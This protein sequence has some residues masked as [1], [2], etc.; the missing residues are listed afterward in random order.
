[1]NEPFTATTARR[2]RT[3]ASTS[4]LTSQFWLNLGSIML[5]IKELRAETSAYQMLILHNI[6]TFSVHWT[7]TTLWHSQGLQDAA[8][9]AN[10][11]LL[12]RNCSAVTCQRP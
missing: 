3:K 6:V 4:Q 7:E 12:S 5:L 10:E 8:F 9:G 2:I 1:M 11:R